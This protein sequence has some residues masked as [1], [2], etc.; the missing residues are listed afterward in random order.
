M[1]FK[2]KEALAVY[3]KMAQ[4]AKENGTTVN[5][6]SI[7]GDDCALEHVGVLA[8]KTSGVVDIVD[9]L[10]LGKQVTA[11]MSKPI[12]ATG[13]SCV[14]VINKRF[15]F[16]DSDSNTTTKEVGNVTTDTDLTFSY[17]VPEFFPWLKEITFQCQLNLTRP[18]GAKVLRVVTKTRPVTHKREESEIALRASVIGLHA[19]HRSAE[20]AQFK[21]YQ[22][23]RINLIS[24]Q[25]LLQRGMKTKQ[26][27]REYINFIK[28]GEK[29]DGFMREAKAQEQVLGVVSERDDSAAKNIIQMKSAP[30]SVFEAVM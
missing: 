27:Q 16:K 25:R 8:D 9:P 19:V 15:K 20:M 12:L 28:Q 21:E 29:L 23:A 26:Q 13:L 1:I 14:M 5:V 7:R 24:V 17:T 3:T 30:H 6:I 18:D 4:L 22:N 11:I 10:D 2:K